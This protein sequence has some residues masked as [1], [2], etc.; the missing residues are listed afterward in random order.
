MKH[1]SY[2]Y[3]N[4]PDLGIVPLVFKDVE[5]SLLRQ[6]TKPP[7]SFTSQRREHQ[8]RALNSKQEREKESKRLRR[9]TA[10]VPRWR[11]YVR[12]TSHTLADRSHI[13]FF[14]LLYIK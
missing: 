7:Q 11:V 12:R 4:V 14:F 5:S 6:L 8:G 10:D 2:L 9:W 13:Y 1:V 3:V